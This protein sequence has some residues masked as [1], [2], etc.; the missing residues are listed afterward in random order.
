MSLKEIGLYSKP[1]FHPDNPRRCGDCPF[2]T[3]PTASQWCDLHQSPRATL[4]YDVKCRPIRCKVC[5]KAES[6]GSEK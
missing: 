3:G 1:V 4:K 6:E 5:L 2:L